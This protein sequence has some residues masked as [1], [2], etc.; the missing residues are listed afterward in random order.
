MTV[1]YGFNDRPIVTI[2]IISMQ[3]ENI[4]CEYNNN[5][6]NNYYYYHVRTDV[7]PSLIILTLHI[8]S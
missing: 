4:H 5:N 6:N 3:E 2:A 8:I 7:G 1:V